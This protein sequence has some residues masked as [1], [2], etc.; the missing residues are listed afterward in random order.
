MRFAAVVYSIKG[1]DIEAAAEAAVSAVVY[2][3]NNQ[4]VDTIEA[5]ADRFGRIEGEVTLP[6]DGRLNG[7][8]SIVVKHGN[9]RGRTY[10]TVSDYKLPSFDITLD[11]AATDTPEKAP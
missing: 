9:A 1:R 5:V 2:D 7:R 8:Y 3:A 6:D 4:P 11:P 10:F